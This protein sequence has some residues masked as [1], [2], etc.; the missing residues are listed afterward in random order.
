V[1]LL[2]VD[3]WTDLTPSLLETAYHQDFTHV[4]WEKAKLLFTHNGMMDMLLTWKTTIPPHSEARVQASHKA[5]ALHSS[6]Q[7]EA[8]SST[9]N[10]WKKDSS[11]SSS[12]MDVKGHT[13]FQNLTHRVV[14][15]PG[16]KHQCDTQLRLSNRS[17]PF[18][19]TIL[20]SVVTFHWRPCHKLWQF[21]QGSLN[22]TWIST[23]PV[24]FHLFD[25]VV[26]QHDFSD[27]EPYVIFGNNSVD[28]HNPRAILVHPDSKSIAQLT[29]LL[30]E[31][32]PKRGSN[33]TER[34]TLVVAGQD[35]GLGG[36]LQ[37][38]IHRYL[39]DYFSDIW[40]TAKD[41]PDPFI[42]A[43]PL[44]LNPY[45]LV[46]AGLHDVTNMLQSESYFQQDRKL[47]FTGR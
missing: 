22:H 43:I 1:P 24:V 46:K 5:M 25:W 38:H 35:T 15:D 19:G 32:V 45:Y 7:Q 30:Q 13:A 10:K 27:I 9:N 16:P 39:L 18:I 14:K 44:G 34:R 40:C 4:D 42:H 11:S 41:R 3:Q 36:A 31:L 37:Y 23:P 33:T 20:D 17:N 47:V 2:L 6:A 21:D 26:W 8:P 28:I 29:Y 12:M